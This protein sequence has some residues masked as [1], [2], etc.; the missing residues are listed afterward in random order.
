MI[1]N[2]GANPTDVA[3]RMKWSDMKLPNKRPGLT[4]TELVCEFEADNMCNKIF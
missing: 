1:P 3:S 4:L 2:L